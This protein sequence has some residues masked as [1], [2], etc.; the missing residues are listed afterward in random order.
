MTLEDL[1]GLLDQIRDA[2]IAVLG[3]FCLDAY[4]FID[5]TL[6]ETSL[7]TRLPTRPVREQRYSPGGAGNVAANLTAL[8]VAE[9]RA[10]G[11]VGDDLFGRELLRL[12]SGAGVET[13]HILVQPPHEWATSVYAKPH[14]GGREE[15][16]LDFG[17]DN[18]LLADAEEALLAALRAAAQDAHVLVVNQQLARGVCTDRVIAEANRLAA[19]RDDRLLLVD[20]RHRGADF[21]NA[22]YRLNLEEAVRV[23]AERGEPVEDPSDAVAVALRLHCANQRPVFISRGAAG[24]VVAAEGRSHAVPAVRVEG[25]TDPVGAGDTSLAAIAAALAVGATPIEAAELAALAAAVT[26]KKLHTTG[27]VTP[28]EILFLARP[29]ASA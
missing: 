1:R 25:P 29:L 13:A 2:R 12:L 28:D 19:A 18:R 27:T 8:G 20:A 23:C 24:C 9:V 14:V 11:V 17:V 26:V 22:A 7:E 10:V 4:W 16:R 6:S 15:G 5:P 21:R 3:D